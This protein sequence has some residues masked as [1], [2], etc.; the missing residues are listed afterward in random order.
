MSR[1]PL[2]LFALAAAMAVGCTDSNNPFKSKSHKSENP[3]ANEAMI[4]MPDVP[5][6]VQDAFRRDHPYATIN[7]VGRQNLSGGRTNYVFHYTD[8]E[9][10]SKTDTYNANAVKVGD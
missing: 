8:R 10:K 7:N 3:K 5:A 4:S 9:G 6:T 2:Y 1:K